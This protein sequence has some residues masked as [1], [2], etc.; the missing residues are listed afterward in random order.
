MLPSKNNERL[1]PVSF[2]E[3]LRQDHDEDY[4]VRQIVGFIPSK[5][6]IAVG[7]S[8][9]VGDKF[10][11]HVQDR[12]AALEDLRLMMKR[13]KTERLFD[14]NVG[15]TVAALQVSCVARGR[16]L[17]GT[18]NVD[19]KGIQEL[20]DVPVGGFFANGEIG[21]VGIAGFSS[22][23][24]EGAFLHGFTTVAALICD[25]SS[26]DKETVDDKANSVDEQADAWG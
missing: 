5:N 1:A 7:G 23:N 8:I 25:Y 4:L 21:P 20:V 14:E 2:V 13:A 15:Q 3:Y 11:F 19:L 16:G 10:R 24:D 26:V 22:T 17:F 18:P 6:G 12:T 9:N